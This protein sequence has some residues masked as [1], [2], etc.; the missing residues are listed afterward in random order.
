MKLKNRLSVFVNQNKFYLIFATI[1]FSLL[2][3]LISLIPLSGDDWAWGS[4][5]GINN[6]KC[7]FDGYN[8]RYSGN[9]TVIALTRSIILRSFVVALSLTLICFLPMIFTKKRSIF[10]LILTTFV[11]LLGSKNIF[12]QGIFWASGFS[13]YVPPVLLFFIYM[14]M[15]NDIFEEDAPSYSSK[16]NIIFSIISLILSF[17]ST[18]FVENVTIFISFSAIF[19]PI[20]CFIKFKKVPIPTLT[21]LVGSVFGTSLMFSNTVYSSLS[22]QSD[23]YRVLPNQHYSILDTFFSHAYETSI[24]IFVEGFVLCIVLSLLCFALVYVNVKNR[25]AQPK[26]VALCVSFGV[27]ALCLMFILIRRISPLWNLIFKGLGRGQAH[28]MLISYTVLFYCLSMLVIIVLCVKEKPTLHRLLASF[29]AFTVITAPMLITN[30]FGPRVITP[31]FISLIFFS[32]LLFGYVNGVVSL[33]TIVKE[34]LGACF[35]AI[36][37][38][39]VIFYICIYA[40]AKHYDNKRIEYIEKQLALGYT[41]ITVCNIPNLEYMHCGYLNGY[42]WQIKYKIYLEIDIS[43]EFNVISYEEFDSWCK[44]FDKNNS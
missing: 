15:M 13:N 18:M 25:P 16:K 5:I 8:G 9:L 11:F 12:I 36:A 32:A 21:F 1:L 24:H 10:C 6:L 28:F 39:L 23:G 44:D 40:K 33:K 43:T 2:A 41:E 34:I 3:I 42:A 31:A 35:I 30:P 26:R 17:V 37:L 14:V 22:E 27:N 20:Y 38:A 19:I 7:W 4:S 29:I